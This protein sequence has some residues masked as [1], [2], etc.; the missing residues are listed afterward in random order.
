MLRRLLD[1]ATAYV[2]VVLPDRRRWRSTFFFA[3]LE[4]LLY[5]CWIVFR[6]CRELNLGGR[7]LS[8]LL[9]GDVSLCH[10]R[11]LPRLHTVWCRISTDSSGKSNKEK[12]V[13]TAPYTDVGG[14][15]ARRY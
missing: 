15:E 7:L 4:K 13:H 10:S 3:C 11:L 2:F 9:A 8:M 14:E 5:N 1:K 12:A 6:C